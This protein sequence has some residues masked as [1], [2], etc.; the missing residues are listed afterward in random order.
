[1]PSCG[2]RGQIWAS[3][4]LVKFALEAVSSAPT[5]C[6]INADGLN[7][8]SSRELQVVHYLAEGLNNNEIGV[9]LGL[10]RHTIKI[11]F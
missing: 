6:A 11:I 1:M 4:R 5:I 3:S 8:L 2:A 10:S 9:R 7:V